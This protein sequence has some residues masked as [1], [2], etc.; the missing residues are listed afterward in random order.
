MLLYVVK[1]ATTRE[2]PGKRE[3]V[4]SEK[5]YAQQR[6]GGGGGGGYWK[7]I[8][9]ARRVSGRFRFQERVGTGNSL[10]PF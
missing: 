9:N 3:G 5:C 6:R 4:T 1:A 8:V 10:L 2:L 7:G